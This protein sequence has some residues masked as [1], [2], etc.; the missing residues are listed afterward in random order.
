MD[1]MLDSLTGH[2]YYC[3]L[4]GLSGF[5]QLPIEPEDQEK[6]M[7]HAHLEPL[8]IEECLLDCA[9]YQLLSKGACYLY[10]VI[11]LESI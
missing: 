10:S 9:I 11:W 1:Q 7:S 8:P 6:T 3:L 4:D 2:N 5:I